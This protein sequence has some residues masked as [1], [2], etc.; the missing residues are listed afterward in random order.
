MAGPLDVILSLAIG[1]FLF[2]LFNQI[3]NVWYFGCA[4]IGTTYGICLAAAY[5]LIVVP[6]E[7][8]LYDI[9]N[10]IASSLTD[11]VEWLKKY[12]YVVLILYII[13]L[14]FKHN[15][16]NESGEKYINL[17]KDGHL[18]AF[19]EITYR[20]AFEKAFSNEEWTFT[21]TQDD[22]KIVEFSGIH[23]SEKPLHIKL[24]FTIENEQ[25]FSITSLAIDDELQ[26]E[27]TLLDFHNSIF[28]S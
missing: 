2:I 9:P 13:A 18:N 26:D 24:Q 10:N 11:S 14:F 7:E 16:S 3:F 5:N 8:Q 15:N 12:W 25:A 21:K 19:P 4:A 6:I 28:N 22:V 17:V 20:E 27:A 23:D 1:T